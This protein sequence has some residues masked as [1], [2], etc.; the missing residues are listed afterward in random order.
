M[1]DKPLTDIPFSSF[2]LHPDLLAGLEAAGFSRCTPIQAMTLPIALQGRDV[3]GQAQTGTGK[4]LA[5]LVAAFNRLLS[6]P[7]GYSRR[8]RAT[9]KGRHQQQLPVDGRHRL[10]VHRQHRGS[11]ATG[12]WLQA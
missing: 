8:A 6:K 7:R 10:H 1:T 5:F 4:T 12:L 3:A 2:D 9:I 11:C